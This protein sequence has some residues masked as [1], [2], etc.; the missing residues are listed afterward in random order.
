M[1]GIVLVVLI[2]LIVN[3]AIVFGVKSAESETTVKAKSVEY[4]KTE[5]C[6]FE[7]YYATYEKS[8]DWADDESIINEY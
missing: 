2:V 6:G 3:C 1:I 5:V 7:E 4:R 8:K